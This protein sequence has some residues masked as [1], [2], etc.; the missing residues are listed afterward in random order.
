MRDVEIIRH[1]RTFAHVQVA[2]Y[3]AR[4]LRTIGIDP[5]SEVEEARWLPFRRVG[6]DLVE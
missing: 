5:S 6:D 4:V 1:R 2:P 3:F